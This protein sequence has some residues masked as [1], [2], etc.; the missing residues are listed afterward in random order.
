MN[1]LV[2]SQL[3]AL[4]NSALWNK[5]PDEA[6]FK[7]INSTEWDKLY[8]FAIQQGVVAIAFDGMMHLSDKLRPPLKLRMAWGLSTEQIEQNYS[9][10]VE[11]CNELA[12][13]FSKEQIDMLVFKGLSLSVCYPIAS[14]REF[15]DID[16]YLFGNHAKGDFLMK[17][18]GAIQEKTHNYK[19]TNFIYKKVMIENHAYFLNVRD[20][21]K[22]QALNNVLLNYLKK[23][24]PT[25]F[26]EN[27][28]IVFPSPDFTALFFIIHAIKHLSHEPLPLRTFCDWAMFLNTNKG[29]LDINNWKDSLRSAGLLEVAEAVTSL[30]F[31]W[32]DLPFSARFPVD[33]NLD[34]DNRITNDFFNPPFPVCTNKTLSGIFLYKYKRFRIRTKRHIYLY[35]GNF[36]KHLLNSIITHIRQPNTIFKFQ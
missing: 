27:E 1:E 29:K 19:H 20:S 30:T 6:L 11:A 36:A 15:G 7:N 28:T 12:T 13:I 33:H 3:L 26:G 24:K 35:G 17:Q 31:R 14:H 25:K 4:V 21:H 22:I 2:F 10:R 16:I 8:R 34:W 9:H 32:F 5:H 23:D 18:A